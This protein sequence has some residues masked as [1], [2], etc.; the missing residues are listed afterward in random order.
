MALLND[1]TLEALLT[2]IVAYVI[3]AAIHG[4]ILAGMARL[5]G[6]PSPMYNGRFTLNPAPHLSMPAL[7]MTALFQ[8]GWIAPMRIDPEKLRLGRWGLVVCVLV[9]VGAVLALSPLL[10]PVRQLVVTTMPRTAGYA[11]LILLDTIQQVAVTFAIL[12]ILPLPPLTGQLL[13]V[14][15]RPSIA[16]RLYRSRGLFEG[17][18]VVLAITGAATWVVDAIF[19]LARLAIGQT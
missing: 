14:A 12:N 15:A 7:A 1:L 9:A 8:L 4:F 18:M 11:V 2:R 10:W 13:L 3:I 6:D 19:A 5:M 16:Q 17:I